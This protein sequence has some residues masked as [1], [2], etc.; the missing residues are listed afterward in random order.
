MLLDGKYNA[1]YKENRYLENTESENL[2]VPS[3]VCFYELPANTK[4]LLFWKKVFHDWKNC[5]NDIRDIY[6]L[7]G[8]AGTSTKDKQNELFVIQKLVYKTNNPS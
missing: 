2:D 1:I 3:K 4:A 8:C 7:A 6:P 5:S